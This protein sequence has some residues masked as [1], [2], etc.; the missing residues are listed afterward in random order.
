MLSSCSNSVLAR[1]HFKVR[2]RPQGPPA[3]RGGPPLPSPSCPG[4]RRQLL[5]SA[6]SGSSGGSS[7][8]PSGSSGAG[9]RYVPG[10][11]DMAPSIAAAAA[12]GG[13]AAGGGAA[14]GSVRARAAAVDLGLDPLAVS[15]PVY[16]PAE[17]LTLD[18]SP[19]EAF[20]GAA[21]LG[22]AAAHTDEA[23]AQQLTDLYRR[24]LLPL[25]QAGSSSSSSS[26]TPAPVVLDLCSAALSH[27]PAEVLVLKEAG[28]LQ[29]V[30]HGVNEEELAAN[31]AFAGSS[32][33]G[34]SG[35]S[36]GGP[37]GSGSSSSS[38]WTFTADLNA[39]PRLPLLG[40]GSVAAVLCANGMQ[41]LTRPEWVLAEVARVLAPGG[42]VVVAFSD[43]CWRERAAAGWLGRS[44]PE[45]LELV[46]RLFISAGL[47]P[48]E[49]IAVTSPAGTTP[50]A[51]AAQ[52]QPPPPPPDAFYALVGRKPRGPAPSSPAAA[53]GAGADSATGGGAQP[54]PPQPHATGAG[55][56]ALAADPDPAAV[57]A[58]YP[59]PALREMD[60]LP[61]LNGGSNG[62][63]SPQSGAAV[64]AAGPGGVSAQVLERWAE[65]YGQ[66]VE[67]A[68]ELGVPRSAIPQLPPG[69]VSPEQLRAAR[70][71]LQAM[72][73]SFLSAGL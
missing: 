35:G 60:L 33:S 71:H 12:A 10:P 58:R 67:D 28:R 21:R 44:G 41:Y 47:T 50:A 3:P 48:E 1:V 39:S 16:T 69:P 14:G 42:V 46:T 19:A 31:P 51:A 5:V 36:V 38:S 8:T 25:A 52:P 37:Q 45:R 7:N 73:A 34:S 2:G 59:G 23:W 53:A 57:A 9:G 56:A 49:T 20:F 43:A 70:D 62:A 17:R 30:G 11:D 64:A 18:Q 72:I 68:A 32:S 4:A 15:A 6:A 63:A 22:A 13:A 26:R 55:G 65:A 29:L 61:A 27:L 54:Q 24:V 40:A 66:L